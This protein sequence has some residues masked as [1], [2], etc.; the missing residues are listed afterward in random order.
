MNAAEWHAADQQRLPSGNP[1]HPGGCCRHDE[2]LSPDGDCAAGLNVCG[3]PDAAAVCGTASAWSRSP[4]TYLAG[5]RR[6]SL[7][8]S[9]AHW[10][11]R[12]G[13]LRPIRQHF[14]AFSRQVPRSAAR[15]VRS[16][17]ARCRSRADAI[18]AERHSH[19]IV[20]APG[21]QQPLIAC[22]SSW[23]SR[24]SSSPLWASQIRAVPPPVIRLPP[25]ALNATSRHPSC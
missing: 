6:W 11:S 10:P 20:I 19:R 24:A 8:P 18:R 2:L 7:G 16:R 14:V 17:P 9:Q 25:S 13:C 5:S 23:R 4:G 3:E 15:S 12:E 22:R 21:L 1:S